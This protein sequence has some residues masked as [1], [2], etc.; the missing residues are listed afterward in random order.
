MLLFTIVCLVVGASDCKEFLMEN[1]KYS[2][3]GV[4]L[5]GYYFLKNQ[6]KEIRVTFFLVFLKN[7]IHL[8]LKEY[9]KNIYW[10]LFLNH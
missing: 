3:L 9:P 6:V 7:N 4:L 1:A 8:K 5:G 10:S 2:F